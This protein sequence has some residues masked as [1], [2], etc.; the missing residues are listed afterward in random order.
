MP[1][2]PLFLVVLAAQQPGPALP[3][4][5][6]DY[7]NAETPSRLPPHFVLLQLTLAITSRSLPDPDA[8]LLLEEGDSPCDSP[9]LYTYHNTLSLTVFPPKKMPGGGDLVW[10]LPEVCAN[11]QIKQNKK[12]VSSSKAVTV[13][14]FSSLQSTGL[15]GFF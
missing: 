10:H 11:K 2:P 12:N 13:T 15:L 8:Y 5:L 3:W 1:T 4:K 14:Y 9:Q 6:H 7:I